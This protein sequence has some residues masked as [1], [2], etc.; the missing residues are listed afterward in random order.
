MSGSVAS[1]YDPIRVPFRT[2]ALEGKHI[3]HKIWIRMY[4]SGK[5]RMHRVD[6]Y[7]AAAT[8]V[9]TAEIVCVSLNVP[10][11]FLVFVFLPSCF[12]VFVFLSSRQNLLLRPCRRRQ[13]FTPK[14][15]YPHI[16]TLDVTRKV[17]A[18]KK[19]WLLASSVVKSCQKEFVCFVD[20]CPHLSFERCYI[21]AKW[22][23]CLCV[24]L[25][26]QFVPQ[27]VRAF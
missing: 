4:P 21:L 8:W 1:L 23:G 17:C 19:N 25:L 24:G 5:A 16:K 15:R 10:S 9:C 26:L 13:R 20:P 12:L 14:H 3:S 7:V 18:L 6:A 2:C 27:E 11:C 22:V